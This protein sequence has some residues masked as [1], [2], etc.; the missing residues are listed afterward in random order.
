MPDVS[1]TLR[2]SVR[3]SV[4][5]FLTQLVRSHVRT[6]R[7]LDSVATAVRT[8]ARR[9]QYVDILCTLAYGSCVS[10]FSFKLARKDCVINM[11]FVENK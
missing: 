4:Y 8:V 3:R 7:G 5:S 6:F 11:E 10:P 9:T 2:S 1:R